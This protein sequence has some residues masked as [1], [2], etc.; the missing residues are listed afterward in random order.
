MNL[1][2]GCRFRSTNSTTCTDGA[3][4][5][6]SPSA[7]PAASASTPVC[8]STAFRSTSSSSSSATANW[9]RST[10]WP[11][12]SR[13]SATEAL[14]KS[15]VGAADWPLSCTTMYPTTAT[16]HSRPTTGITCIL[17]VIQ[18]PPITRIGP[19]TAYGAEDEQQ[20]NGGSA[21]RHL[22]PLRDFCLDLGEVAAGLFRIVAAGPKR[23]AP[24]LIG[25]AIQQSAGPSHIRGRH[26]V[27]DVAIDASVVELRPPTAVD[28]RDESLR[29]EPWQIVSGAL[30]E[31][32]SAEPLQHSGIGSA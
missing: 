19:V 8:S 20:I 27:D 5:T 24:L 11:W 18:T 6:N 25:Q 10:I 14:V 7:S 3:A 4:F 1:T 26:G 22:K 13:T 12:A 15:P 2:P 21:R 28:A 30:P 9:P 32:A 29:L 23:V 17:C 31:S 16:A